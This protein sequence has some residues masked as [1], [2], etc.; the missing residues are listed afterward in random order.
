MPKAQT[1]EAGK[2]APEKE[3]AKEK[4]VPKEKEAP[5]KKEVAK[6]EEVVQEKEVVKGKKGKSEL[7]KEQFFGHL[8]N[9]TVLELADYIKEFEERYGVTAAAAPVAMAAAGAAVPQGDAPAEEAKSEFT[10]VLKGV[11][12][13]KINVIKTVREVTSLGLKEAKDL[14]DNAPK[15]VKENISKEEAEEMKAK[16]EAVGAEIEL[17]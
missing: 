11:G 17:Q 12:D 6:E 5:E 15:P 4:E 8:D 16:F 7:T 13:K 10:V 1:K 2:A 14:V 3:V 9:L